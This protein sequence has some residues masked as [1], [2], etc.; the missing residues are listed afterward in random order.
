MNN[1]QVCLNKELKVFPLLCRFFVEN[2]FWYLSLAEVAEDPPIVL[3]QLDRAEGLH[4]L[5]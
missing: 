4:I 2:I 5:L 1:E 3:R